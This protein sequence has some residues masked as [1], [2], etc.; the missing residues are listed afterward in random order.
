MQENEN[1]NL[2]QEPQED[3]IEPVKLGKKKTGIICVVLILC[4]III[5]LTVRGCSI[6]KEVKSPSSSSDVTISQEEN[7]GKIPTN[8]KDTEVK[9]SENITSSTESNSTSSKEVTEDNLEVKD[10]ETIV[11]QEPTTNTTSNEGT[12][13]NNKPLTVADNPILGSSI[14]TTGI[15]SGKTTY[16]I[17]TSYLYEVSIV[18]VTGNNESAICKY[19]CPKNTYDALS[20]G[21]S[22]S[23][24]YQTD[25][26]GNSSISTI[27]K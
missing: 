11:M 17:G 12:D 8:V 18:V 25:S 3:D 20:M 2:N 26:T 27:S 22:L 14:D 23:V 13:S 7:N 19:Y 9:N 10:S 16:L 15:V 24:T 21:D 1:E 4:V 5:C 6:S